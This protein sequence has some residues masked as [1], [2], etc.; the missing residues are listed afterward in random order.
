MRLCAPAIVVGCLIACST[1]PNVP[2][3]EQ[4]PDAE[5]TYDGLVRVERGRMQAAWMRPD[6]DLGL[7]SKIAVAPPTLKFRAVRRT[8]RAGRASAGSEEF[9]VSEKNQQ[10]LAELLDQ[11]FRDELAKSQHFET[12]EV[13][14]PDVL[15]LR[16]ALI[17][18]VSFVPPTAASRSDTFLSRVGEAT[19][20]IELADSQSDETLARAADRRGAEPLTGAIWSNTVSSW[21][22]VRRLARQW[23]RLL[24]ERLDQFHELGRIDTASQE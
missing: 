18:I 23:A 1:T 17:D 24:R 15:V 21:S 16:S 10:R 13:L 4:G 2:V 8:S 11:T 14:G 12:V 6:M 22:E 20:V 9:P 3:I 19:L 5:V 7:Y